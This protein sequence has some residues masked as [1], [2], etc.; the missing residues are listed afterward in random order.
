VKDFRI[1]L[2]QCARCADALGSKA[3]PAMTKKVEIKAAA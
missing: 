1:D 2:D 3:A